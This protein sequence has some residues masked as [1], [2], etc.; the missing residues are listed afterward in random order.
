MKNINKFIALLILTLT[1]FSLPLVSAWS[2]NS[3]IVQ[4]VDGCGSLVTANAVYTLNATI[5]VPFGAAI[6]CLIVDENNITIKLNGFNITGANGAASYNGIEAVAKRNITIDGQTGTIS[7][8]GYDSGNGYGIYLSDVNNSIIR[9]V[10]ST[11][12]SLGIGL[13]AESSNNN[14][15][16]NVSL[17][18]NKIYGLYL[19]SNN[20]TFYTTLISN[21]GDGLSIQL[22][23]GANVHN[24]IFYGTTVTNNTDDG[25]YCDFCSENKFY[26]TL[27]TFNGRYG[28]ML[29]DDSDKNEFQDTISRYNTNTGIYL[30]DSPDNIFVNTV[31]NNNSGDGGIYLNGLSTFN[32]FTNTTTINNSIHGIYLA[33]VDGGGDFTGV[34]STHNLNGITIDGS[35]GTRIYSA[36]ITNNTNDGIDIT[37]DDNEIYNLTCYD[38][39]KEIDYTSGTGNILYYT[40]A[41]GYIQWALDRDVIG[42]LTF[43]TGQNIVIKSNSA[44]FNSSSDVEELNYTANVGLSGLST[45]FLYPRIYKDAAICT[46]CYNFTSLNAGNVAFNVTSWSTYSIGDGPAPPAPSVCTSFTTTM[47][48]LIP[49]FLALAV[50]IAGGV[51]FAL[52]FQDNDIKKMIASFVIIILGLVFIQIIAGISVATCF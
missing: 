20:N 22:A 29:D 7:G 30:L 36:I 46:D 33:G 49:G 6:S 14:K 42:R 52:G 9:N 26:N 25:I 28:L 12:N 19:T 18:L 13:M 27:T 37:G 5:D 40:N 16:Y 31:S 34:L 38:N 17:I 4:D 24:N 43:G 10:T 50:L 39:A 1:V 35:N 32:D 11:N 51:V 48:Y 2:D 23:S 21:N 15:F 47:V 45:T 44:Y 41:F 3:S 8:F